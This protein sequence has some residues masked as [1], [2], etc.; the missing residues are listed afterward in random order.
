MKGNVYDLISD[1]YIN[2]EAWN[3]VIPKQQIEEFFR[4]EI[5]HNSKQETLIQDWDRILILLLFLGKND[6]LLKQLNENDFIDFV[7][8]CAH[9]IAEFEIKYL[10][11]KS[12]LDTLER[13]FEYLENKNI[14]KNLK[15]FKAAKKSLL[16]D[17]GKVALL[18]SNGD[19]LPY[20]KPRNRRFTEVM[21]P[22]I[23]MN[24]Y[25]NIIG[26]MS[27]LKKFYNNEEFERDIKKAFYWY[28]KSFALKESFEETAKDNMQ[29]FWDYFLFDYRLRK[30][31]KRPIDYFILRNNSKYMDIAKELS[32]SSFAIFT[33]I[34]TIGENEYKCLNLFTKEEY[35]LNI[36]IEKR[37]ISKN[38]VFM[39]HLFY[40]KTRLL[41]SLHCV[42]LNEFAQKKLYQKLKIYYKYFKLQEKNAT[43]EN[44]LNKNTILIRKL[45]HMYAKHNIVGELEFNLDKNIHRSE[46][47]EEDEVTKLIE[48]I[49]FKAYFS[50]HDI[51]LAS[52][53]WQDYKKRCF[54]KDINVK[55]WVASVLVNYIEL[56]N[57]YKISTA[58]VATL[59]WQVPIELVKTA[60]EKIKNE[61][62]L[63]TY[64]PRYCNEEAFVE[65]INIRK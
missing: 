3:L 24:F 28:N 26:V 12:F 11:L 44:F 59:C 6:V 56:N 20:L 10:P 13:F 32:K 9:N 48:E 46:H 2:D 19:L 25:A 36:A 23:F 33:I 35:N 52:F 34:K 39:S 22:K 64:D 50:K 16:L 1:F 62:K 55:I 41:S 54:V 17:N 65:S 61:L 29:D 14:I 8:W 60:K 63:V 18:D 58:E 15:F 4:Y 45:V 21:F 43:P 47:I 37:L 7:S 51:E 30:N 57:I 49:M 5:W 31:N 42:S 27:D 40:N 38:M 53:I